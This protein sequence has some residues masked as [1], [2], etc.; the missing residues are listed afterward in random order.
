MRYVY[1]AIAALLIILGCQPQK[2][3]TLTFLDVLP[4]EAA[5]IIKIN[6]LSSFK[7]ELKN[8]DYL[9]QWSQSA[10]YKNIEKKL[11]ALQYIQSDAAGVLSILPSQGQRNNYIYSMVYE[12]ELVLSDSLLESS[13]ELVSY[14]NTD[15]KKFT[16][17]EG[18]F[19]STQQFNFLFLSDSLELLHATL[20]ELPNKKPNST[21]T[22]LYN[23][24]I[25]EKS[26]TIFINTLKNNPVTRTV[27]KN[28]SLYP[29]SN[30]SEWISVDI[31]SQQNLVQMSGVSTDQDST[32]HFISLF[33][34]TMPIISTTPMIA[35]GEA[36]AVLSFSFSDQPIF[37]VNQANYMGTALPTTSLWEAVEEVG[38]ILKDDQKG[39]ILNTYGDTAISEYL[40]TLKKSS[41]EYQG[42]EIAALASN[43]F[44]NEAFPALVKD[45]NTGFYTILENAFIFTEDR[46]FLELIIR[47][48]V[49][50]TTF[51]KTA[52]YTSAKGSLAEESSILYIANAS[53]IAKVINLY[54]SPEFSKDF[55]AAQLTDYLL[56]FQMVA[57]RSFYHVNG[58]VKKKSVEIQQNAVTPLFTVQLDA[59][60]ATNP[61]FVT[62]HRTNKKEIVVQDVENNLYLISSEGK[63]LWK[64]QLKGTIQ[65][66]IHQID[67]YKNGRL[68]LAFTTNNQFLIL[69][70]N[71]VEVAPFS[72]TYPG[73]NLN[74]LAVFDYE[75]NKNYRFLVTQGSNIY[76]YNGKGAIVDGF[77]YTK[78]ESPVL[79]A[80]K[81][82]RT[83][84]KDYLVFKLENGSLEILNRIGKTRVAVNEQIEF[85]DNDVFLYNNKFIVSDKAGTL[86]SI[87]PKGKIA[88]TRFNLNEDYGMDAT[89]KTLS[90][91]NDNELTIKGNKTTLDLGVYTKPRI[92]YIYD[93][94]Y[95]SVT[96]IQ[97]QRA[98]LFDSNAEPISNFPVFANS[99]IDLT[100]IDNDRSIEFVAKYE[101]NSIIAYRMN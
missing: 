1:F 55:Q 26:G 23:T 32:Q 71:G 31:S 28:D 76:M 85:S 64:K 56:A 7:S 18:I 90:L 15:F 101:D 59:N 2:A 80:P 42:M 70:R 13:I 75:N 19:Y 99:P 44:L 73:A 63:I 5:L 29:L 51:N 68:Q 52:A 48:L 92:F 43:S 74:G 27:L 36:D 8:N 54:F 93:K 47:N 77:K 88:K 17:E 83:G 41:S 25:P 89:T 65:G 38:I 40:T 87:D 14:R 4:S 9:Q 91:M 10:V 11:E 12:P 61:Q 39:I 79:T 24:S 22:S 67:L 16:L 84:T 57:D 62:N 100:D 37:A 30:F 35:P 82:F 98:Y 81:H 78:A 34:N 94:I 53:G 97:T 20:Q 33:K 96:D 21:L 69:D 50:G 3:T 72:F 60:L 45:F 58:F 49:S 6:N 46:A 86:F 66:I 95:V